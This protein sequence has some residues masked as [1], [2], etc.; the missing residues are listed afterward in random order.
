M[1]ITSKDLDN[2]ANRLNDL[3]GGTHYHAGRPIQGEYYIGHA[4]GSP[5]LH[6]RLPSTGERDVSPRLP[7]G[8]LYRWIQAFLAGFYLGTQA[9]SR[10]VT[11]ETSVE[12]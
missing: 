5:R 7:S 8:E 3:T 10:A 11:I 6:F 1:R 9:A 4:Y 12:S 2:L